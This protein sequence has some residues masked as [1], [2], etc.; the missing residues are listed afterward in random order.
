METMDVMHVI[1]DR[2]QQ[3]SAPLSDIGGRSMLV[4]PQPTLLIRERFSSLKVITF[5]LSA[6]QSSLPVLQYLT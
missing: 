6:D 2:P 4:P 1:I 5:R 3:P